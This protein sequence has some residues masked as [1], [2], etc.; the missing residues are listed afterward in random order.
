LIH[1]DLHSGNILRYGGGCYITYLGL[2]GSVDD[3][4]S[5]GQIYGVTPYVAPE[6]LQ[7][8]KN[9]KESDIY[10]VGML[11]WEIFAGPPPFNDR[12]HDEN[13]ILDI[14]LD[15]TRPPLLSNMPDDFTRMMQ[16]CWDVN[17]SNRPTIYELRD[18]A[19]NK[20]K[21]TYNDQDSYN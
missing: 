17:P 11:L 10:S 4:E 5:S 21:D 14:V 2:C 8:K 16:K 6:V 15:G 18:F 19:D 20:L 13:L 12:A 3:N 9:T 7:G 1:C